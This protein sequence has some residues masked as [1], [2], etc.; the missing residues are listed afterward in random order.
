MNV[1]QSLGYRVNFE[2]LNAAYFGVAQKRERIVIVGIK[3]GSN[4]E[5]KYPAPN[6]KATPLKEALIDCPISAGSSYSE[7][8]KK[9]FNLVPPGGC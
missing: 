1:F 2:I 8:K 6:K 4:I 9:V 7:Y 3:N 5:Y